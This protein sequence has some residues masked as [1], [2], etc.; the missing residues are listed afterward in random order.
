[1]VEKRNILIVGADLTSNGGIASVIK[2]Y[3]SAL[4]KGNYCINLIFIRTNY[5]KDKGKGREVLI[6][7]KSFIRFLYLILFSDIELIH[8]H[9]S[10]YISFYRKSFFVLMARILNKKIIMHLHSSN[11]YDFF[12]NASWYKSKVLSSCNCIVVLCSDWE[13]SLKARYHGLYI[14]KIENPSPAIIYERDNLAHFGQEIIILFVG[15]LIENKGIKDLLL[16]AEQL[17]ERNTN[18]VRIH[19][20]G[21]GEMESYVITTIKEKE[22]Q[23]YVFFRGWIDKELKAEVYREADIF[24]L[25]SYKEGMPI[26]ILEAMSYGL[27]VLS[28][29]ISGIPDLIEDGINGYLDTPGDIKGMYKHLEQ[30]INDPEERKCM[31][32]KNLERI[33]L[34]SEELIFSQVADLYNEL[35]Q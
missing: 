18:G 33:K 34:N 27:P 10:A 17:K 9:S 1:L 29:K 28:T 30:L 13:K 4:L 32:K 14:R 35:M 21:K 8:V 6:F 19:I 7:I 31:G 22:L 11:F 26:S 25:P 20:A 23:D 15:F 16:I 5:Y 12:L 3:H 24:I 2:A